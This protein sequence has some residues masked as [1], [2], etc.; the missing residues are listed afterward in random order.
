MNTS[1]GS[2]FQIGMKLENALFLCQPYRE[3]I[4]LLFES[5]F[6]SFNK[7]FLSVKDEGIIFF[8]NL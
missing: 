8:K 5:F 4:D 3:L 2:E 7:V 1:K 6:V